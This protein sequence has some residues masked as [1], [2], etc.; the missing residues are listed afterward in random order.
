MAQTDIYNPNCT[1]F[2][3]QLRVTIAKPPVIQSEF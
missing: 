3:A 2:G 1:L